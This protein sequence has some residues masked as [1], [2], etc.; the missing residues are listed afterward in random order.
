MITVKQEL[1]Y[2]PNGLT[3]WIYTQQNSTKFSAMSREGENMIQLKF[4][5]KFLNS[6]A[7]IEKRFHWFNQD[8]G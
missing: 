3:I 8:S 1:Y 4:Y 7:K 5:T 6:D 2:I